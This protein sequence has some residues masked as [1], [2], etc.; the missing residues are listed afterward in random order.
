VERDMSALKLILERNALLKSEQETL[1]ATPLFLTRERDGDV[2]VGYERVGSWIS[3]QE[4]EHLF[5]GLTSLGWSIKDEG[6]RGLLFVMEKA[7]VERESDGKILLR[8][9]T[10]LNPPSDP[11]SLQKVSSD[12]ALKPSLRKVSSDEASQGTCGEKRDLSVSSDEVPTDGR[13][14][15]CRVRGP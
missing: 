15:K 1:V 4:V 11:P 9:L 14:Q 8:D 5:E 12:K 3:K 10:I 2:L 7:S 6:K 13:L